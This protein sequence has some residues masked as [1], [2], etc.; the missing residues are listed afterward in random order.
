MMRSFPIIISSNPDNGALNLSADGSTFNIILYS[1]I[2]F[3]VNTQYITCEVQGANIWNTSPNI[4]IALD[5]DTFQFNDGVLTYT[6]QI[7]KGLYDLGGLQSQLYTL[8]NNIPAAQPAKDLFFLTGNAATQK[9]VVTFV[10]AGVNIFWANSTVRRILGFDT[11]SPTTAPAGQSITAP[12][13]AGFNQTTSFFIK[14]DIVRNGI[15]VNQNSSSIAANVFIDVLPGSLINYQPQSP[16]AVDC[17]HLIGASISQINCQLTNQENVLSDTNGEY[18][19][20]CLVF[21]YS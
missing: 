19:S 10:A 6:L 21:R 2:S 20:F 8:I 1:P 11:T 18:Y 5:N 12:N 16:V 17:S 13:V 9:V 14:A 4:S 3:P 15:P 7:P